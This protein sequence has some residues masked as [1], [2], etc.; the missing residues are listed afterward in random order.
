[1]IIA[2][3]FRLR[4]KTSDA[5]YRQRLRDFGASQP[6]SRQALEDA[7]SPAPSARPAAAKS[8]A[9]LLPASLLA[10]PRRLPCAWHESLSAPASTPCT[11]TGFSFT[12]TP[13]M[14]SHFDAPRMMISD[15]LSRIYAISPG[16]A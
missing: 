7:A 2:I 14:E 10:M 3:R 4:K 11:I 9:E 8:D 6:A 15:S 16:P 1:M 12:L 5:C 13:P